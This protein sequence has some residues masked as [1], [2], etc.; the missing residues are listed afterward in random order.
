[1]SDTHT[2]TNRDIESQ[3]LLILDDRNESNVV[4]EAVGVI[5]RRNGNGD[6]E[7]SWEIVLAVQRFDI[8]DCI[9]RDK[10][11]VQPDLRVCIGAWHKVLA[12]VLC[13]FG[14]LAV[15]RTK[16]RV[17]GA[18]D[19]SVHITTSS[20]GIEH[21]LVDLLNRRLQVGLD[22]TMELEGLTGGQ[23]EGTVTPS[24]ANLIN[25]EPLLGC[26]DT[27]RHTDSNHEGVGWLKTLSST[28]FLNVSVELL[29]DTVEL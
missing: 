21:C 3:K 24:V 20:N 11:L 12:N 7:L 5:R 18:H 4:A 1:M 2:T 28:L 19:V 8:L 17:A 10:L 22:D 26:A 15:D 29:V 27:S 6:L 9:A 16:R 13:D 23:L 14:N 25:S